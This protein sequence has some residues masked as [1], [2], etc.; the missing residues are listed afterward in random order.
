MENAVRARPMRGSFKKPQPRPCIS[1]HLKLAVRSL[2]LD[3]ARLGA[4]SAR[5][6]DARAAAA[7]PSSAHVRHLIGTTGRNK[8]VGPLVTRHCWPMEVGPGHEGKGSN[9]I[10]Y[11]TAI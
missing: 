4:T 7:G 3:S 2:S 8:V 5:S 6:G 11:Y 10:G 9:M 1:A